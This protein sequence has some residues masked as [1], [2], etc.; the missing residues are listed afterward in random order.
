VFF[1]VGVWTGYGPLHHYIHGG[2]DPSCPFAPVH[3]H[4]I[5]LGWVGLTLFGLVYRALPPGPADGRSPRLAA[6]HLWLSVI[7]VLGVMLNGIF[8]YR[9]LDR[10]SPSFYYIPDFPTLRLWLLIDAG[11]LTLYALAGVLFVIVVFRVKRG[12]GEAVA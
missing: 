8:G 9:Y 5:L 1:L 10:L 6:I 4:V 3:G 7:S 2:T 11:F 12:G